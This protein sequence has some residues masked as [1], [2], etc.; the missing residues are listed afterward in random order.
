MIPTARRTGVVALDT[1]T[2]DCAVSNTAPVSYSAYRTRIL[3]RYD[4]PYSVSAHA[5]TS[6]DQVGSSSTV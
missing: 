5:G 4:R 1:H 2:L 6:V 3:L